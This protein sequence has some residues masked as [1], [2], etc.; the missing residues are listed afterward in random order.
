MDANAATRKETR[1]I[2]TTRRWLSLDCH[3]SIRTRAALNVNIP[4]SMASVSMKRTQIFVCKNNSP[5]GRGGQTTDAGTCRKNPSAPSKS[6]LKIMAHS[7]VRKNAP[8]NQRPAPG[9]KVSPLFVNRS[10][11]EFI[12]GTLDCIVCTSLLCTRCFCSA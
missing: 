9:K 7:L 1:H 2:R 4:H 6:C 10:R 11:P 12:S 5:T 8:V 3:K